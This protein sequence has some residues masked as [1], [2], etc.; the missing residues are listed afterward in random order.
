MPKIDDEIE[1]KTTRTGLMIYFIFSFTRTH[2]KY[3]TVIMAK[4]KFKKSAIQ[5]FKIQ[6]MEILMKMD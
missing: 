1:W 5:Q 3:I 6:V 4:F 2:L